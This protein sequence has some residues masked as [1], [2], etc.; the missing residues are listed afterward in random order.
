MCARSLMLQHTTTI[1]PLPPPPLCAAG[2]LVQLEGGGCGR[3][4]CGRSSLGLCLGNLPFIHRATLPKLSGLQSPRHRTCQWVPEIGGALPVVGRKGSRRWTAPPHLAS[5]NV[6]VEQPPPS[7]PRSFR[8]FNGTVVRVP[9]ELTALGHPGTKQGSSVFRHVCC[10][11]PGAPVAHLLSYLRGG[12]QP[13]LLCLARPPWPTL[14]RAGLLSEGG[15][16]SAGS[17]RQRTRG[18]W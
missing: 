15:R 3:C 14:S 6:V 5:A 9:C 8:I 12:V 16:S 4:W 13:S 7:P 2:D 18:G 10:A 11:P 17:C 1:H